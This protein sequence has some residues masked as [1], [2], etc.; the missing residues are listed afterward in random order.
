MSLLEP[1]MLAYEF[2]KLLQELLIIIFIVSVIIIIVGTL[3][4]AIIFFN[5]LSLCSAK[6]GYSG[7]RL[8]DFT[9]SFWTLDCSSLS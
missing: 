1:H 3:C 8:V 2:L 7:L 5:Q 9:F 6:T 4:R